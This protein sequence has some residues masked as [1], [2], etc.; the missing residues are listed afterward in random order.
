MHPLLLL[1]KVSHSLHRLPRLPRH[2]QLLSHPT[3]S[4]E[5]FVANLPRTRAHIKLL[6]LNHNNSLIHIL[7]Q[8]MAPLKVSHKHMLNNL[9]QDRNKWLILEGRAGR[10]VLLFIMADL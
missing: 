10:I 7:P 2:L 3:M 6:L 5:L 8:L 1:R 9:R 4:T